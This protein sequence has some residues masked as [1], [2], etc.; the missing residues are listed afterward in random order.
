MSFSNIFLWVIFPYICLTV[1]VIGIWWRWRTDQF[2]WTS[3]SSEMYE[4]AWLRASSPLFHFGIL[5]VA[6]GHVLGLLIPATWTS[7]VGISEHLYHLI[8]VIFGSLAGLMTIVGLVGLLVRRF[9][10]KSVRLATSRNDILMYVLLSIPIALGAWATASTQ[11]FGAPGGYDYRA[12]ISPWLRSIFYFDPQVQ[13]MANVP[14][15]FKLHIVAAFLLFAIWP[16][17]RLVHAL[18][19]PVTYPVRP[20]LVYRSRESAVG[21]PAVQRGWESVPESVE[22]VRGKAN[23][24]PAA[25]FIT[26]YL[27]PRPK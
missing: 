19:P 6:G 14:A 15:A 16:F 9:V 8:A 26:R 13:L 1:M 23:A 24:R 2:G 27:T 10:T 21:A 12:T 22:Q 17:T 25:K 20:Y 4:R 11:I 3:R 5:M 18:A 7:A